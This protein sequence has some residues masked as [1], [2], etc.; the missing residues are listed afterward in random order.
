M[1]KKKARKIKQVQAA[2]KITVHSHAYGE[3]TRAARGS[4][5]PALLNDAL[6]A[7]GRELTIINRLGSEV[8]YLLKQ[9]AGFFKESMLWQKMLSRMH[10]AT[11]MKPAALLNSLTGLE[12]NSRYPFERFGMLPFVTVTPRKQHI[13]IQLKNEHTLHFNT[14]AAVYRYD[15][16]VLFFNA[17]GKAVD[18]VVMSSKW[19]KIR[20]AAGVIPFDAEVPK[21]SRLYLICLRIHGGKDDDALNELGSQGMYIK[22]AGMV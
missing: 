19:F 21:N 5:K 20:E 12:L 1:P 10:N 17:K 22:Q 13:A 7:K 8:H 4:I 2:Q 9:Y 6:I 11:D 18:S 15:V 14:K 3:H 16:I